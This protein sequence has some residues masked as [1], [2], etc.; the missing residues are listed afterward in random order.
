MFRSVTI[1][2]ARH[3]PT[4]HKQRSQE[5]LTRMAEDA[6]HQDLALNK[7]NMALKEANMM[8]NQSYD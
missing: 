6:Q 2:V 3:Q 5:V 4:C 7:A 1:M 8:N